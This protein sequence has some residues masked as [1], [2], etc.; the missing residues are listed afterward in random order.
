MK[1]LSYTIVVLAA[2][3]AIPAATLYA[4]STGTWFKGAILL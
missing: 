2:M 3:L 4:Q 1:K